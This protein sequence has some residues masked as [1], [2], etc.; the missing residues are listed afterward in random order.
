MTIQR[1]KAIETINDQPAWKVMQMDLAACPDAQDCMEFFADRGERAVEVAETAL[2][3]QDACRMFGLSDRNVKCMEQVLDVVQ[4]AK[5]WSL[6]GLAIVRSQANRGSDEEKLE[7]LRKC[8][9]AAGS[10]IRVLLQVKSQMATSLKSLGRIDE[11]VAQ[12]K[13]VEQHCG[14]DNP[15]L[16]S[17]NLYQ[18]NQVAFLK[19]DRDAT[20]VYLRRALEFG[21]RHDDINRLIRILFDYGAEL[22]YHRRFDESLECF[23]EAIAQSQRIRSLKLEGLTRWQYG[24]ALMSMSRPR[25]ALEMLLA[26][27]DLVYEANYQVAEK[28]I[29]LK[30][31]DAAVAQRL[32]EP[33]SKLLGKGLHI[34]TIENRPFALSEEEDI[35]RCREVLIERLGRAEFERTLAEGRDSTWVEVW[36]GVKSAVAAL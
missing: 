9:T 15:V 22:A 29:F 5:L 33:A 13:W 27:V 17:L 10:D 6:L 11:T 21:R 1:L 14:V 28:W 2:R 4:D 32:F 30:T 31:V 25:E 7:L 23:E 26:S 18:Q 3:I 8:E 35:R 24:D 34:R 16:L 36:G 19:G 20:L 12:L